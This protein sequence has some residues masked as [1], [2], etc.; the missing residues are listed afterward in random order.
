M[1]SEK[2]VE[3]EELAAGCNSSGN[4]PNKDPARIHTE[5]EEVEVENGPAGSH[6]ARRAE[7]QKSNNTH[8]EGQFGNPA[9]HVL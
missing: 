1:A 4:N 2:A 7:G 5:P 6:V 3:V 8:S 9:K